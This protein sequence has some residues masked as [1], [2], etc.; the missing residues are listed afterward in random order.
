MDTYMPVKKPPEWVELEMKY[1]NLAL[2]YGKD[3]YRFDNKIDDNYVNFYNRDFKQTGHWWGEYKKIENASNNNIY[4]IFLTAHK[5]K[6]IQETFGSSGAITSISKE[7]IKQGGVVYGIRFSDDFR[8]ALYT[9]VTDLEGLESLKGSKYLEPNETPYTDIEQ[10]LKG[11]KLVLFIGCPC[12]VSGV[13]NRFKSYTNLIT[14]SLICNSLVPQ[15]NWDK[16]VTKLETKHN[17]KISF[18]NF[19]Y[20]LNNFNGVSKIKY[21]FKNGTEIIS[22][23]MQDEYMKKFIFDKNFIKKC[24]TECLLK[25]PKIQGDFIVGDSWGFKCS[26]YGFDSDDRTNLVLCM[27]E[28]AEKHLLECNDLKTVQLKN[29]ESAIN[30]CKKYNPMLF[31]HR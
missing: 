10:D 20:K 2:E 25:Y 5:N 1:L 6:E 12:R 4:S 27:N 3:F 18:V 28:K 14:V 31:K 24:C 15:E 29:I 11:N 26:D 23:L 30:I 7:V 13:I 21:S 9:R 19:K 22:G 8:Q 16:Y 17:S